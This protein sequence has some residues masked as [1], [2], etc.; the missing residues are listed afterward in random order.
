MG[1]KLGAAVFAPP[2]LGPGGIAHRWD[3]R[4]DLCKY[5]RTLIYASIGN[6]YTN[7]CFDF[8]DYFFE[9]VQKA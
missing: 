1:P 3:I 7:T 6:N 4:E 8:F 2:F 9:V 5:N